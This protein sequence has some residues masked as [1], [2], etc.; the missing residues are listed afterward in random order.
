LENGKYLEV[1]DGS[2]SNGAQLQLNEKNNIDAQK[3]KFFDAGN[4]QYY[5]K[6]KVT[7]FITAQDSGLTVMYEA[8]CASDQKWSVNA[9]LPAAAE[10]DVA[11]DDYNIRSAYGTQFVFDVDTASTE[12]QG[13]IQLYKFNGTV[14]Q[15]FHIKKSA[16][17]WYTI[18]ANCSNLYLDV[19]GQST[20]AGANLWQ[21]SES[22]N[23]GQKFK[24]YQLPDGK[25]VIKS[26]LGTVIETVDGSK[27]SNIEMDK[28]NNTT[29]QKWTLSKAR[30]YVRD[31]KYYPFVDEIILPSG[32]YDVYTMNIGLKVIEINKKLLGT[33]SASFT[34]QTVSAVKSFQRQKGLLDTGIVNKTTWLAMGLTEDAWYNLGTYCTPMGVNEDSLKQEYIDVM[35][36]VAKEYADAGTEYRIGCSATFHLRKRKYLCR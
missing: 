27:K 34:S 15:S 29:G 36:R 35:L 11:E 9:V 16:D 17:G 8:T 5:I 13:N 32:G 19:E 23:D 25:I 7:T 4:G 26:K 12:E 28:L 33:T 6:G 18:R 3:F 20:E 21:M 10:V 1:Q 14:A 30:G 31:S 24:F 22:D 2:K